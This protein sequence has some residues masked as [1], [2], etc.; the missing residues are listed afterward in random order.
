M[1][2]ITGK[3]NKNPL[4]HT[5]AVAKLYYLSPGMDR[6]ITLPENDENASS[7]SGSSSATS[8]SFSWIP[9]SKICSLSIPFLENYFHLP[10]SQFPS[11]KTLDFHFK[12]HS[13]GKIKFLENLDCFP[14]CL[15]LNLSY[16]LIENLSNLRNLQ[17]LIELNLAENSIRKVSSSNVFSF[18][19]S[20]CLFLPRLTLD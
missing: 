13:Y 18:S 15:Q 11:L 4:H 2:L 5:T 10:A 16:N 12:N 1:L 19:V 17:L 3:E 8:S 14:N 20:F 6:E 9:Q 7:S